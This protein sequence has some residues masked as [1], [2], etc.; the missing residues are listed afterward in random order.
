VWAYTLCWTRLVCALRDASYVCSGRICVFCDFLQKSGG[1][2]PPAPSAGA[3]EVGEKF[4]NLPL[5]QST[6]LTEK[7]RLW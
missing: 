5:I 7:V 6:E 2:A 4:G 3:A 1:A